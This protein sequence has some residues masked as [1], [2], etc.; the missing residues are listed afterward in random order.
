MVL[1]GELDGIGAG[2]AGGAGGVTDGCPTA[3]DVG[4]RPRFSGSLST[5]ELGGVLPSVTFRT[6][7]TAC[8]SSNS[9]SKPQENGQCD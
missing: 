7:T 2:G 8:S 6:V 1:T 5:A 3:V 9:P 4:K